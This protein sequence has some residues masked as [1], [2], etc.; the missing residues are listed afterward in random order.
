MSL[1]CSVL[2]PTY[3]P[4]L[5]ILSQVLRALQDQTLPLDQWELILIDNATPDPDLV[6]QCDLSWHPNAKI[7][8]ES[9][10]GLTSARLCGIKE[11]SG[12]VLCFVD[13]D[14]KLH[15]AYLERSL[16]FFQNDSQLGALGGKAL[17][18]FESPPPDWIEEFSS[19][20][21]IRDLGDEEIFSDIVSDPQSL[22]D[23]PEF[24]PIGAGMVLH[25]K[26]A[27]QYA[28]ACSTTSTPISDRCGTQLSSSG[29]NDI[30]LTIMKEGWKV[31]YSPTLILEH[32]IAPKRVTRN[33]LS[34]MAYSTSRS[35]VE[36]LKKHD[37]LPWDSIPTWSVP[38]RKLRSFFRYKAWRD[39]PSFIRWSSSCGLFDSLGGKIQE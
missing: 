18:L 11:A 14:N 19:Y 35:W 5:P 31:A 29:D 28:L 2:L 30:I 8:R 16:D 39:T 22:Q 37:I 26:A 1:S 20:L 4:R 12:A 9:Q 24:A 10:T 36:V 38:L 23:Y 21:A 15:R 6:K 27:Q 32:L 25:S 33:Y 7:V 3:S 34:K 13:D 17:P